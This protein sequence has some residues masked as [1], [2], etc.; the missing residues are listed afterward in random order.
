M[1]LINL[2]SPLVDFLIVSE[3]YNHRKL[4]NITTVW[5]KVES[6]R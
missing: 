3:C 5:D 2:I 4:D 1:F 6:T